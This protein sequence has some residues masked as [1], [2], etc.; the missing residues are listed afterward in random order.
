ML[1][2]GG[3]EQARHR[4]AGAPD[5]QDGALAGRGLLAFRRRPHPHHLAGIGLAI[6]IGGEEDGTG[7]RRGGLDLDGGGLARLV[8]VGGPVQP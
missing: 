7:V 5:H 3:N 2:V 4:G 6:H 8:A 1:R